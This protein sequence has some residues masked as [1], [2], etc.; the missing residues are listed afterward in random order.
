MKNKILNLVM[1]L[2]PVISIFAQ[3]PPTPEQGEDAFTPG[4]PSTPID[5]YLI[6]LLIV[7]IVF[8][9]YLLWNQKK[10]IKN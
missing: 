7:A 4:A 3:V 9:G 1:L 10:L 5:Q 6:V 8:A 2:I